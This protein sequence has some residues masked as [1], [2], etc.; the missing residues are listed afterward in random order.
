MPHTQPAAR[1]PQ[2]GAG[3]GA[4]APGP[5]LVPVSCIWGA[6]QVGGHQRHPQLRNPVYQ[7][8]SA[9]CCWLL[10]A[11]GQSQSGPHS[12]LGP[13]GHGR[14][15]ATGDYQHAL[16]SWLLS[17]LNQLCSNTNTF[18][19]CAPLHNL[20]GLP[21]ALVTS[22]AMQAGP[23]KLRTRHRCSPLRNHSAW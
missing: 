4:G 5:G 16:G 20:L 10:L 15:P 17:S 22:A 18:A 1:S 6:F 14:L 8:T 21:P 9:S 11:I 23:Q 2:P 3:A 12:A 13:R 19:M 7:F